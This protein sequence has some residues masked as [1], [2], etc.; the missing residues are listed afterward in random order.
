MF[1]TG[2]YIDR[3]SLEAI[4]IRSKLFHIIDALLSRW[5]HL[6]HS[7]RQVV[8]VGLEFAATLFGSRLVCARILFVRSEHRAVYIPS[9][10]WKTWETQPPRPLLCIFIHFVPGGIWR[11]AN[12]STEKLFAANLLRFE[13]ALRSDHRGLH[14]HVRICIHEEIHLGPSSAFGRWDRTGWISFRWKWSRS[15]KHATAKYCKKSSAGCG[16]PRAR[17]FWKIEKDFQAFRPTTTLTKCLWVRFVFLS[18]YSDGGS[19][20]P[21][22]Y[23]SVHH[24]FN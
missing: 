16:M 10:G 2:W 12:I 8:A 22:N 15:G 23:S 7:P 18:K 20:L 1:Q 11:F 13:S 5:L 6:V 24:F 19:P 17:T 14:Y 3:W 4:T 9:V 21:T